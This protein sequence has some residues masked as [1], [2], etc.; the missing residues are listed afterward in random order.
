MKDKM[1]EELDTS[2]LLTLSLLSA[3]AD[4]WYSLSCCSRNNDVSILQVTI[5]KEE[6]KSEEEIVST[7]TEQHGKKEIK[8]FS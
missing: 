6:N 7:F 2:S 4:S 8:K 5:T 1:N 3:S